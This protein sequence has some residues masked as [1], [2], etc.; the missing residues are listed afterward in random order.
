MSNCSHNLVLN[1]QAILRLKMKPCYICK[2]CGEVLSA[3]NWTIVEVFRRIIAAVSVLSTYFLLRFFDHILGVSTLLRAVGVCFISLI[4]AYAVITI[5][6]ILFFR[7]HLIYVRAY[8]KKAG[9]M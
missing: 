6:S 3:S 7:I 5:V 8:Y 1:Y 9:N 4:P 2:N